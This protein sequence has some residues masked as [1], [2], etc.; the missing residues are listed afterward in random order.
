MFNVESPQ[1]RRVARALF[2]RGDVVQTYARDLLEH[3]AFHASR[4]GFDH[5]AV[6]RHC[7]NTWP[8]EWFLPLEQRVPLFYNKLI[9]SHDARHPISSDDV[10][11]NPYMPVSDVF[12]PNDHLMP[13]SLAVI[14]DQMDGRDPNIHVI[15]YTRR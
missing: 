2:Q 7:S 14:R 6:V 4:V 5:V 10:A 15:G 11:R 3:A 13:D 8:A 1:A 12:R 9:D